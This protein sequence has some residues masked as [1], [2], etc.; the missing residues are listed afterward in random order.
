MAQVKA[1]TARWENLARY[2]VVRDQ[3]RNEMLL[4]AAPIVLAVLAALVGL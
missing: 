3:L 1:N 2:N 4:R